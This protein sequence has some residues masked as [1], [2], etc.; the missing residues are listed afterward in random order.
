MVEA[1]VVELVRDVGALRPHDPLAVG[2]R[3]LEQRPRPG[4]V[5][6]VPDG[7]RQPG[8]GTDVLRMVPAEGLLLRRQEAQQKGPGAGV[9]LVGQHHFLGDAVE[10]R[11]HERMVR[12]EDL[13]AN[14]EGPPQHLQGGLAIPQTRPEDPHR[15]EAGRH[16]AVLRPEYSRPDGEPPLG[17]RESLLRL[18]VEDQRQAEAV[19]ARGHVRVIGTEGPLAD[20]QRPAQ[21]RHRRFERVELVDQIRQA[22]KA[23][24]HL[25]V[26]RS[27]RALL[28]ADGPLRSLPR[29]GQPGLS[30]ADERLD[31][32]IQGPRGLQRIGPRP[33]LHAR[34]QR[35][36]RAL[37]LPVA[38]GVD[39]PADRPG[40]GGGRGAA[41]RTRTGGLERRVGFERAIGR[42]AQIGLRSARAD[43]DPEPEGQDRTGKRAP[44]VSKSHRRRTAS[45]KRP[46]ECGCSHCYAENDGAATEIPHRVAM[47]AA[48]PQRPTTIRMSR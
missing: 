46:D 36:R 40:R 11:R 34:D 45:A 20:L 1:Q 23:A 16:L 27:E 12:S 29:R 22:R 25:G 37:G 21:E 13:L 14:G 32:K 26:V 28:E 6:E 10:R 33:L 8:H 39:R 5:T 30:V 18:P 48:A 31:Q 9:V 44:C 3:P 2:Q 24:G 43:Q 17:E 38:A 7:D 47:A 19:E 41:G 35:L 15:V 42:S 4:V